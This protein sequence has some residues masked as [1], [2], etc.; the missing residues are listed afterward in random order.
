MTYLRATNLYFSYGPNPVLSG[1]SI[2]AGVGMR[3]GVTGPNGSGKSTLLRLLAGE[4]TAKSGKVECQPRG[5][6]VGLV[7]QEPTTVRRESVID[8]LSRRTGVAAAEAELRA[9][10][11]DYTDSEPSQDRYAQALDRWDAV[12]A[13][14]FDA[15]ARST[16]QSLGY[17]PATENALSGGS[18][19]DGSVQGLSGGE[20]ARIELAT[21]LLHRADVLLLDEPTNNLDEV[22]LSRLEEVVLQAHRAIVVVSHDRAFLERTVTHVVEIDG[23]TAKSTLYTGGWAAYQRARIAKHVRAQDRYGS[24]VQ[25]RQR[26]RDRV[27]R[28]RRWADRGLSAA[29]KS[30]EPDRNIKAFNQASAEARGSAA[31]KTADR[32]ERLRHVDKPFEGWELKLTLSKAERAG[33]EVAVLDGVVVN[34]GSFTLGPL[35]LR[36]RAGDRILVSGTN[37]SGKSTLVNVLTGGV[38]LASGSCVV[39]PSVEL[40]LLSQVRDRFGEAEPLLESFCK[41]TG[42]DPEAS[43]SELAKF[44]LGAEHVRRR[45]AN[46]SPGER[47]RAVLA[48]FQHRGVNVLILDEPTNHLDVEAIEQLEHALGPFGGTLIVI[49]HDVRFRDSI[50]FQRELTLVEGRLDLSVGG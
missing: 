4:L 2:S 29:K 31:R 22:G 48:E 10:S 50:E 36:I 20:L 30:D 25:E 45:A 3:V 37:G 12:G 34:L 9:A 27:Q 42:A 35:D 43:R 46:L 6:F 21:V 15:R 14:D 47:T 11:A 1:V 28:E 38:E 16:L 39:G 24:Y 49:S 19:P 41:L 26:L 23:H 33:S 44:G 18:G 8:Y 13:P 7:S 5:A 40:G 17:N 32:L